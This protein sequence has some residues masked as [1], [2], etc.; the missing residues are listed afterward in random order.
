V[1]LWRKGGTGPDEIRLIKKEPAFHAALRARTEFEE[2]LVPPQDFC[3][4]RL[5][6]HP[7]RRIRLPFTKTHPAS[8]QAAQ[9]RTALIRSCAEALAAAESVVLEMDRLGYSRR[10]VFAVRLA[11]EEALVNAIKHGHGHDP[12][13]TA[14]LRCVMSAEEVFA[15]VED[16]GPGFDHRLVADPRLE[17]NHDRP[18]GR[19]LLLMRHYLTSVEYN[20]RGNRVVLRLS[21]QQSTAG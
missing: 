4:L 18:G 20:E 10:D 7:A 21:R 14:R 1:Q 16:E 17:E 15:E 11:L 5:T 2:L 19:G 8:R 6:T 3:A 13:K 9:D 12:T